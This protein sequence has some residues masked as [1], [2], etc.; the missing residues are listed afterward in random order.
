MRVVLITGGA[1]FIGSN[2]AKRCFEKGW[3]VDVVDDLSNGHREFL[4][5]QLIQ[6]DVATTE[7]WT[8]HRFPA[9]PTF[10]KCDF[11][12]G[13]P[14]RRIRTG[15]YDTVFHLAALPRVSYSVEHPVE[16]N[17]TN[18]TRTLS[19]LEACRGTRTRVI[20]ASS[21]SVY[22]GA[23]ALP[24]PESHPKDPKSPYALQK[25]IIEDYLMMYWRLYGLDSAC[26]R[27][28]NV[29]GE[30]QLGDSPYS[31]AVSAWLTAIHQGRPM[32][33]DGT[34]EQTRDMCYVGNVVDACIAA[35]EH[36][37]PLEA[38]RFNVACGSSVSNM[39]I[40]D[41]LMKRYPNAARTDAPWRAGDV[42]HTCADITN[43]QQRLGYSPR[44]SFWEGLDRTVEWYERSWPNIQ[45]MKLRL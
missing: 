12:T 20:F 25:S 4:P 45:K 43:I 1:G 30:N 13:S 29:F 34:G 9:G 36:V 17:D 15:T 7:H 27:F 40:M 41:E 38:A 2:L 14:R 44:V 22:G 28:F 35:A 8:G 16:T 23:D 21:S 11:A 39:Q 31:T 18:V 6:P 32:R 10:F 37:E 3:S 42:M 26:M 24:T 19:L 5:G 33:S